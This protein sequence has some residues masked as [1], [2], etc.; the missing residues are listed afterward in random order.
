MACALQWCQ[1]TGVAFQKDNQE[2][3]QLVLWPDAGFTPG[4]RSTLQ[5]VSENP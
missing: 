1:Q 3:Q 5:V 2:P 4:S